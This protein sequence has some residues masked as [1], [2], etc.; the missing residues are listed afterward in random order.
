MTSQEGKDSKQVTIDLNELILK[1]NTNGLGNVGAT[2]YINTVIQCLSYCSNFLKFILGGARAKASTPMTNDLREVYI[3]LWVQQQAIAP[4]GFLRS[5]QQHMGQYLN[6]F[7]QNDITE[8]LMLYLDKLNSDLG[9][10]LLVDD[11]DMLAMKQKYVK[12]YD[13]PMYR[14]L[15]FDMDMSWLK[16]V[17]KEYSPIMDMFYGQLVS[18]IVCGNCSHVHHNYET[19]CNL[20]L[21]LMTKDCMTLD[22][23]IKCYFKDELLNK[24]EQD[25]KCD[26]CT[27][28][29]PSKK[30]LRLWK[31][32][33]VLIIS[34]KRFDYQRGKNHTTVTVPM[35][36]DLSPFTIHSDRCRYRLV[37]VGN[38]IGGISSGH[39]N[40]L[41]RNKTNKWYA[42]D[43]VIVREAKEN[44]I[45]YV[46]NNG[47]LYFYESDS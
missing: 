33:N 17:R 20:S 47:Y 36:L 26:N 21:P 22:N 42:I 27:Q 43:D 45:E 13:N 12:K 5:L 35:S 2:C 10:E 39:Y 16:T 3:A 14:D 18:Q 41:C 31:N 24:K 25:W 4:H 19:Y 37:A 29:Q 15:A 9:I 34:L 1:Y 40:C 28:K 38:H 6:I 7:E 11:A 23:V 32:P 8:F 30:S 44:E 46:L